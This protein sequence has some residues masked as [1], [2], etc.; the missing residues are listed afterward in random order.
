MEK[1]ITEIGEN[2][3]KNILNFISDGKSISEMEIFSL[4]ECK[5]YC[6]K[7][8]GTYAES[9][10]SAIV[11]D[12]TARRTTGYSVERRGDER[13]IQT[14][15]GEVSYKRTYF[16]KASG[17]YEYLTDIAL[18][19]E[20]RGRLSEN[21]S[22]NLVKATKDMSYA[23]ASNY[24]SAGEI[25]RQTVMSKV[26]KS[27][28]LET[29][30]G[31]KRRVPEI[32]IDADEDH[33]TLQ[34]GKK[35]EVPLISVYEGI[36]NRGKRNYCKN[37][38]HISEFGLKPDDLWE[39]TLSE[40]EKRYDLTNT[41]IYLHGD[42]GNW[43]QIGLEWFPNATFVLD[44]YH[45]NKAIK[46]IT[47]GLSQN[48]RKLCDKEI[49][50]SLAIENIEF[51][52]DL[53]MSL[54]NNSPERTDIILQNANYLKRFVAGISICKKDPK[55]NNGGCT[56]PHV[57][58]ILSARLSSRPM[59]WSKQTLKK[60]A[61][62]LATGNVTFQAKQ[63]SSELPKPLRKAA[64]SARKAFRKGSAG[65]PAPNAIGTLPI[66]GKV[67]GTQKLLKLWA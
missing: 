4:E 15:V 35:S 3:I 45:K 62:I 63:G 51:F 1:I 6:A 11:A 8:I 17:G 2:F 29:P 37:V 23:K 38:F 53:I 44:K 50:E 9:V 21:L 28:I 47:A 36:G 27:Y 26:R 10:D 14:L 57:S 52:D 65:L 18:N 32:H 30:T 56:E 64:T 5:K 60:L 42:G 19:I 16:K 54:C 24:V 40:I 55:A 48:D 41:K 13:R 20:K 49:R 67:T 25:S 66:S 46:G 22:L 7:V 34:G 33:I 31:E 39:Q 61:P 12:K 59:A 43:I 58:H